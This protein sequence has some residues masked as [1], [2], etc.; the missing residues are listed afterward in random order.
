MNQW[1]LSRLQRFE[2]CPYRV[3]LQYIDKVA[4]TQPHKSAERGSKIHEEAESFVKGKEPYLP[5]SLKHFYPDFQA[6][7]LHYEAGHI[8]CEEEWGF[9]H[10]WN[11]APWDTA[12][13]RMKCDCVLRFSETGLLI[14]DYKTGQKY[15]NEV[16]HQ[17]QLQLYAVAGLIR[18]PSVEIVVCELWYLDKNE[19]TRFSLERS[20]LDKY[21]A[22]FTEA[23]D[24][25]CNETEFAPNPTLHSCRFCPYAPNKQGNCEFGLAIE[26]GNIV[27]AVKINVP[28]DWVPPEECQ[29]D[30][31]AFLENFGR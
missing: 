2:E 3:K 11:E 24:R 20:E 23:G 16:K 28:D 6:L 13:L 27:Q 4:D 29:A 25:I 21:K 12:W 26:K 31:A 17:Q 30:V 8:T 7:R 18:N 5:R 1:S 22:Y 15:G 14:I 19:L 10:E 9:D